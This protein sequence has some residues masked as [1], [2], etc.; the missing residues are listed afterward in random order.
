MMNRHTQ[1]IK[2][3]QM[4]YAL[5]FNK[6]QK[7]D[8][9][10]LDDYCKLTYTAIMQVRDDLDKLIKKYSENELK[11]IDTILLQI[12]RLGIFEILYNKTEH[13]ICI[14]EAINLCLDFNG[15]ISYSF[16]NGVLD[17][18][19]RDELNNTNSSV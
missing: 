16:V 11:D 9:I 10:E 3:V 6:E 1:R 14:S 17:A 8:D 12:L 18:I 7:P 4:L 19:V 2:I 15:D 5:E 13:K